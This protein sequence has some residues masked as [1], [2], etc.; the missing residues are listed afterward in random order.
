MITKDLSK[1]GFCELIEASNILKALAE[2][3]IHE[4][5]EFPKNI[6]LNFNQN[7]GFVFLGDEEG[8]SWV[9]NDNNELE[10]WFNCSNCGEEGLLSETEKGNN[11]CEEC[12]K[13][14]EEENEEETIEELSLD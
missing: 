4:K 5:S 1:F 6:E 7:S 9:L 2:G 13:E 11:L 10:Q 12:Y 8:D 14:E 3:N